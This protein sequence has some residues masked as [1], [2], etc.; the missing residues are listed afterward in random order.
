MLPEMYTSLTEAV[1]I[2]HSVHLIKTV[3]NRH[4]EMKHTQNYWINIKIDTFKILINNG[5]GNL[6]KITGSFF[7]FCK[8][9]SI[10]KMAHGHHNVNNYQFRTTNSCVTL[11]IH[12]PQLQ[13]AA[14]GQADVCLCIFRRSTRSCVQWTS[15][16]DVNIWLSPLKWHMAIICVYTGNTC[17]GVGDFNWDP[18][19]WSD[20]LR[21]TAF[22]KKI[23]FATTEQFRMVVNIFSQMDFK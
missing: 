21:L 12:K 3:Y 17:V 13:A 20:I 8:I 23:V 2:V 6:S 15:G 1:W 14:H 4:W 11:S 19:L 9:T 16:Y 5:C 7:F 18:K 10:N 22:F